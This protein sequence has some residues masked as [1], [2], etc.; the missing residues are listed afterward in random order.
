MVAAM[1]S[2]EKTIN[3]IVAQEFKLGETNLDNPGILRDI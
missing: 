3:K 2:D 1:T